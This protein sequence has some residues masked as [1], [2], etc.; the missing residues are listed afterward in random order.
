MQCG[1]AAGQCIYSF[2]VPLTSLPPKSGRT[3]VR[4]PSASF[5]VPSSSPLR[6]AS[7][8]PEA[9]AVLPTAD[10]AVA[11]TAASGCRAPIDPHITLHLIPPHNPSQ[12][13][14]IHAFL[15]HSRF[16]TLLTL[17][18]SPGGAGHLRLLSGTQE[19]PSE[20]PQ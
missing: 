17:S 4:N 15:L 5:P 19:T 16:F 11:A 6:I 9:T 3:M 12:Y 13:R 18:I 14:G 2:L 20:L 8:G 10:L 1:A 7:S